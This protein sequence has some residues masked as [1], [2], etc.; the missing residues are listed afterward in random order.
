MSMSL[1]YGEEFKAIAECM[2]KEIADATLRAAM[3]YLEIYRKLLKAHNYSRHKITLLCGMGTGCVLVDGE[4]LYNRPNWRQN[5]ALNLLWDIEETLDW[6]WS[7]HLDG[8]S[9]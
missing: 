5:K 2:D 7:Y 6:D 1:A 4:L 9:L 8:Q 3:K